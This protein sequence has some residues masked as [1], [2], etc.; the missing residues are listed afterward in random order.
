MQLKRDRTMSKRKWGESFLKS[1]LPLEHLTL[2]K[3][4][5]LDY[6]CSPGYEYQRLDELGQNKWFEL[7]LT[8]ISGA[9]N[10]DTRICF[11]VE[12]KYHDENRFWFFLPHRAD[13]WYVD[14]AF[15]NCAPYETLSKPKDQSASHIAPLSYG[16]I[17][18]S[19]TGQ[20]Q[21]NSVHKAIQ[22]LYNAF[23]PYTVSRHF[24]MVPSLVLTAIPVIVTNAKIFRLKPSITS[25]ET[26]REA[27]SQEEIAD[28]LEWTWCYH[29]PSRELVNRNFDFIESFKK[30]R[31]WKRHVMARPLYSTLLSRLEMWETRPHWVAVININSLPDVI[32]NIEKYFLGLQTRK[33][34]SIRKDSGK[35]K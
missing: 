25:I 35:T 20:K 7:D 12:C 23:V 8:A 28:E 33:I 16:G 29:E 6:S 4:R 18:L 2:I 31:Y 32:K 11:L 19:K 22:Q 10:K 9:I 26:I 24:T 14:D 30:Q 13:R 21:D 5:S 3:F 27:A 17:V 1:G 34:S 15:L